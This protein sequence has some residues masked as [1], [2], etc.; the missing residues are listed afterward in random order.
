MEIIP[1]GADYQYVEDWDSEEWKEL[2]KQLD[3]ING[4][5]L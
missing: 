3:D 2:E 1:F 4:M 5:K